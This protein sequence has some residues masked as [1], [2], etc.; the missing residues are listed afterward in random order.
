MSKHS[1]YRID[2]DDEEEPALKIRR[3]QQE[4]ATEKAKADVARAEADTAKAEADTAK[5]EADTAKAEADTAK[6]EV[7]SLKAREG[8]A[9]WIKKEGVSRCVQFDLSEC[10]D[11]AKNM[12]LLQG[13]LDAVQQVFACPEVQKLLIP[14]DHL[15][16][17]PSNDPAAE[18]ANAKN[19]LESLVLTVIVEPFTEK[20]ELAAFA[21]SQ[22]FENGRRELRINTNFLRGNLT[23]I[24]F[25]RA[26]AVNAQGVWHEVGHVKGRIDGFKR[27]TPKKQE[28]WSTT[29]K[30]YESGFVFCDA[31][32]GG[33]ILPKFGPQ[34][35]QKDAPSLRDIQD[36][37]L[38]DR[39]L[40]FGPAVRTNKD[41]SRNYY[42]INDQWV[43]R[44]V[45]AVADGTLATWIAG[46][47][48]AGD[49][50][51]MPDTLNS[52]DYT[53]PTV[54][55]VSAMCYKR[56]PVPNEGKD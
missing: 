14:H 17:I 32:N 49:V 27:E 38:Y 54:E 21:S 46:K 5:A 25:K 47:S 12:P 42:Q 40:R 8:T 22:A 2:G 23:G 36:P 39:N 9:P 41:G 35:K 24:P 55:Q 43:A 4:L 19:H 44:F 13:V 16:D 6:A 15:D 20:K 7:N 45:D 56:P 28:F 11:A 1:R 34:L 53:P 48:S 37:T 33:E 31:F 26:L 30:G 51:L 50:L 10:D 18:L 3:L 52:G 29:A